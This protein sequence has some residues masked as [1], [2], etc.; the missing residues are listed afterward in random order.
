MNDDTIHSADGILVEVDTTTASEIQSQPMSWI[1]E[2]YIPQGTVTILIGDGGD[3]KS[4][5]TLALA[6]A[7]SNG[8]PLPGAEKAMLPPSDIIVQNSENPWP[9]VIKPRLEML[10]AN[11]D[12]VHRINA[13][14]KHLTLTDGRI[15]AAIRKH[16][17]K[18]MI[19]DPWQNHLDR[20]FSMNR[21]ES[22]RPAL[23]HLEQVAERTQ[24]AIVLVGHIT[25]GRG[26]AQHRGLGSV[27]VV[28]SVPSA[29][30]LGKAE[31]LDPDVR[32]IAHG[33]SNF[34]ELGSTQLFRLNKIDGFSWIGESDDITPDDIM[35]YKA[36]RV[37][38][39][40]NKVDEAVDFITEILS[41]GDMSAVDLNELADEMGISKRTLERARKIANIKP[42]RVDGHWV[43]SL[44]HEDV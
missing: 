18:L 22:V 44:R 2:L 30:Y 7:I 15:E 43:L 3:G 17:A 21:S 6:A 19:I 39:D 24:S 34:A 37:K 9:T 40:K 10:G 14:G 27:D 23:M 16:N 1:W 26:K 4:F 20:N 28:N 31:G 38:E 41:E 8:L 36:V 13:A 29:L 33:K 25:K 42:R 32:A 12:K 35:R 5:A 11:C